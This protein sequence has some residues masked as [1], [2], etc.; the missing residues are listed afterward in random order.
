MIIV[1]IMEVFELWRLLYQRLQWTENNN[2]INKE[3]SNY[4]GSIYGDS[5]VYVSLQQK[6]IYILQYY[7]T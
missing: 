1:R 5:T 7:N 6:L 4:R 3:S 2:R